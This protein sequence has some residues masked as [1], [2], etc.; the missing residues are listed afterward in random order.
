MELTCPNCTTH[1]SVPDDAIGPNG[2]KVK[3][4]MCGHVWRQMPAD[5]DPM[6]EDA[7]ADPSLHSHADFPEDAAEPADDSLDDS[8]TDGLDEWESA[9]Q[10]STDDMPMEMPPSEDGGHADPL[11]GYSSEI[12]MDSEGDDASRA[13]DDDPLSSIDFG[14]APVFGDEDDAVPYR[15]REEI[16]SESL[17]DFLSAD[18]EPIADLFG[19]DLPGDDLD[20]DGKKG[21][22]A[23]LLVLLIVVMVALGAGAWFGRSALV[24]AVPA[25]EPLYAMVGVD[26]DESSAGLVFK[27]VTSD[28]Q[29]L[30]GVD[31]LV[32]R[33]FIANSSEYDR[34][35]PFLSLVLYDGADHAVQRIVSEPP[36]TVLQPGKTTGFRIKLENPSASARRFDVFWTKVPPTEQ[37]GA[38]SQSAAP[39]MTQ[40]AEPAPAPADHPAPETQAAPADAPA[41]QH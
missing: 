13:G 23:L 19:R 3:C 28:H 6:G 39:D 2:R 25:L 26:V 32:V 27:E 7:P 8:Q 17:D 16:D 15:R 12:P 11:D 10:D 37:G 4:A 20:D 33:G 21:K 40:S 41:A 30:N 34:T 36:A 24:A 29:S 35:L 22:G 1:F 9:L 31:V 5:Y 18:P 14:D 38:V